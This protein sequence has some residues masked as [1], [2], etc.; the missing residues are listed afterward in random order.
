MFKQPRVYATNDLM[1]GGDKNNDDGEAVVHKRAKYFL[2]SPKLCK[3]FLITSCTLLSVQGIALKV[4]K[5][6]RVYKTNDLT[7]G[8]DKNNDDG[9]ALAHKRAKYFLKSPKLCKLFTL[10]FALVPIGRPRNTVMCKKIQ[11]IS[12]VDLK[13]QFSKGRVATPTK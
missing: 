6:P 12:F 2:K 8:G 1:V 13:W 5:Q 11:E 4:F 7:V 10:Y 9:E 3:K